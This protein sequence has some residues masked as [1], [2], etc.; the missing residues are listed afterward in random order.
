[1]EDEYWCPDCE[2]LFIAADGTDRLIHCPYCG[3]EGDIPKGAQ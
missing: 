3:A 2:I 1:M